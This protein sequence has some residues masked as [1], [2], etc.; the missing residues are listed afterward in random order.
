VVWRE[1]LAAVPRDESEIL[2]RRLRRA[3][4]KLSLPLSAE[5]QLLAQNAT[6]NGALLS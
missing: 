2:S 6:R 1:T 4:D 3:A 5:Q